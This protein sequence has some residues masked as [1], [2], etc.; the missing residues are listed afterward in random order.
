M[1]KVVEILGFILGLAHLV[2]ALIMLVFFLPKKV[3]KASIQEFFQI[4]KNHLPYIL[5][6]V[7]MV[8]IH[9]IE[10]NLVDP[11][12]T[13][14]IGV[15]FANN[16]YAF[17]G[18]IVPNFSQLWTPTVLVFF[19]IMYTVVHGF[20]IW[21]LPFYLIIANEKK[22]MKKLA[23]G[24]FIIYS[25]ALP[26]YL[27]L[28]ITN[29]YVF[30]NIESGLEMALPGI[31]HYFYSTTTQNNTFPSLHVAMTILLTWCAYQTNNK[32]LQYFM[33]FVMT[34]VIISVIYLVIHWISDVISGALLSIMA[35]LIL[36]KYIKE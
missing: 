16:I 14:M 31:E 12:T 35:I 6:I 8:I 20:T 1:V 22:A 7:V 3:Y 5:I 2:L 25:V 9:L 27:F 19:V 21:F 29:V 33:I 17:E 34:T 23:Y 30:T 24:F 4:I 11:I 15:D 28:P 10:V 26:F 13:E 18:D 32:K 36:R